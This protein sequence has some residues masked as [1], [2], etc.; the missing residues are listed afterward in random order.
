MRGSGPRARR[1][2]GGGGCV[3]RRTP[4]APTSVGFTEVTS[5][6]EE[7]EGVS[8][9]GANSITCGPWTL[10][11]SWTSSASSTGATICAP[12]RARPRAPPMEAPGNVGR[13][14]RSSPSTRA[15]SRAKA[16][17]V[18][19]VR[20]SVARHT[21]SNTS[22]ISG[23]IPGRSAD[24]EGRGPRSA[25]DTSADVSAA[26]GSCPVSA[27]KASTESWNTS[28]MGSSRPRSSCGTW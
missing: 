23:E 24:A 27:S 25:A 2:C 1:S 19:S 8:G 15:R 16:S 5:T 13:R 11:T 3:E 12:R 18:A 14:L 20:F 17:G 7:G 21:P 26:K 10:L 4:V 6:G 28:A 22:S 9:S